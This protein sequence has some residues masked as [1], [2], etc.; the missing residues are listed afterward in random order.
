MPSAGGS[1]V[2]IGGMVDGLC[3]VMT[4][5]DVHSSWVALMVGSVFVSI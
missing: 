4:A 5:T 3:L 2:S 1:Y